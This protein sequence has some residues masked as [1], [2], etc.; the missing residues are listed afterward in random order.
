V[1]IFEGGHFFINTS[2]ARLLQVLKQEL[3]RH[4]LP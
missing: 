4:E 2:E 3:L 1:K